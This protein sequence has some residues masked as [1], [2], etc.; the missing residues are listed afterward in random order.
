MATQ[1]KQIPDEQKLTYW[2]VGVALEKLGA[3]LKDLPFSVLRN[4]EYQEEEAYHRIETTI[5]GVNNR[6]VELQK[7]ID[8]SEESTMA[9]VEA[10]YEKTR[11]AV[12]S[13][14]SRLGKL[15]K[16]E[17]GLHVG[18]DVERVIETAE[19]LARLSDQEFDR[20]IILV[21]AL[22]G[23]QEREG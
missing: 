3:A 1:L 21:K 19:R 18:Y 11:D 7:A 13:L 14:N 5:K 22:S 10:N 9:A 6:V 17:S 15:P 8:E 20:F 23:A 16:V 12:Q 4:V 2:E